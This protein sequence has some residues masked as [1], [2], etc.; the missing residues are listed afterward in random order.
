MKHLQIDIETAANSP[1][2]Y[3]LTVG[4]LLFDP[5]GDGS[6]DKGW[7]FGVPASMN[8]GR[9]LNVETL[10]WWMKQSE[11]ARNN[12]WVA[13]QSYAEFNGQRVSLPPGNLQQIL[14]ETTT[15][16]E[17][18]WANDPDFD[19]TIM[20]D[21]FTTNGWDYRWPFGK[22]RSMRTLKALYEIPQIDNALA[23]DALADCRYQAAQV[24]T[25]FQGQAPWKG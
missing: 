22:H 9:E 10:I 20:R 19:C 17:H 21:F 8:K 5:L 25:V 13:P 18:I 14:R 16:A 23:H 1:R 3:V 6:E 11:E 4:L 24:R 7:H 15:Q 12:S 2:S